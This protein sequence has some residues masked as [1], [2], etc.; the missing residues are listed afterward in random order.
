MGVS[1]RPA[2]A[3][4]ILLDV[5]HLQYSDLLDGYLAGLNRLSFPNSSAEYTVDDGTEVRFGLE[6]IFLGGK[7]PIALRFGAWSDPDHRIRAAEGTDLA[8]VFPPGEEVNHLTLGLGATLRSIQLDFA[9][10]VSD[11]SSTISFSA[12]HRF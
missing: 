8:A 6:K 9:G 12:I 1:F 7:T 2:E 10:D 11:V 5:V 3:W 4:T